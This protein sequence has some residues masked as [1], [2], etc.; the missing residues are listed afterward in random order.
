MIGDG[1]SPVPEVLTSPLLA[2]PGAIHGF[3]TRR[4]G[5]SQGDFAALN[6]SPKWVEDTTAVKENH[7]ILGR[8]LGYDPQRLFRV[9]QVH[10]AQGVV[11]GGEAPCEVEGL[12]ADFLVTDQPGA[13]LGVITAD[14]VPVLLLDP[15]RLAVAAVHAGWRGLVAGVLEKAVGA[16]GRSYGCLPGDLRAALGPSIGPC[17]FEVGE[18]VVAAF[19]KAY[20]SEPGLVISPASSSIRGERPHVDLWK[21]A[22][23]ALEGAGLRSDRIADPEGCTFCDPVRF[24]SYRRQGPRVGQH[25]SVIGLVP[26]A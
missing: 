24:H 9:F 4:G 8:Y 5:V 26:E 12:E 16:L 17:C 2:H 1:P 10:G 20:P 11:V 25:L 6:F 3:A 7:R 13:V 15:G 22:R 21:S 23:A 18:E 19:R 14:C